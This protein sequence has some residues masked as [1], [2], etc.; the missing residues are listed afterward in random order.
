MSKRSAARV[1]PPVQTAGV[2]WIPTTGCRH[3]LVF[4]DIEVLCLAAG[5][6]TD[7]MQ[8]QAQMMAKA[9]EEEP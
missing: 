7:R 8:Q 3:W 9:I 6:V 5:Q 2:A 4:N 1:E